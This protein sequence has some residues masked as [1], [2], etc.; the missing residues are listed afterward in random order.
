MTLPTSYRP[1]KLVAV[2]LS[3]RGLVEAFVFRDYPANR[4]SVIER[5]W[6]LARE[7]AY[8]E[9]LG[10]GL[11]LLEHSHWDWRRKEKSIEDGR[12]MLLA[13]ECRDETQGLMAIQRSPR[14]SVLSSGAAVVYVD[15][16]EAAPWNLKA[17][18]VAPRYLGVGTILL[19]EAVRLSIETGHE[20]R[21][22]LHSLP[23]AEGFYRR[24]GMN[25]LGPDSA[26]YDLTYFEY[27]G[28]Q[29]VSWLAGLEGPV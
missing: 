10:S 11:Y 22:G 20:G 9:G 12:H 16:V 26:Y 29:A 8:Q 2:D 3:G 5:D 13:L 6:A 27:T 7:R 1:V 21:V 14:H 18:S 23:Q 28:Q 19:A 25:R 24:C 15:Y 17:S 4:L